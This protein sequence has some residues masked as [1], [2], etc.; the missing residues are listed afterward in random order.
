[1]KRLWALVHKLYWRCV[2][3]LKEGRLLFVL[4]TF[5]HHRSLSTSYV[6]DI[7]TIRRNRLRGADEKLVSEKLL[8]KK[9]RGSFSQVVCNSNKLAVLRWNDNKTVTFI[10]SY[11]DSEP[12]QKI[13]RYCKIKKAKIYVDCPNMVKVYNK[14]MG[15]VDLS[16]MLIS[17]YRIPFKSRRWYLN[18]FSQLVDICIN[19]GWLLYR[20]HYGLKHVQ[21]KPLKIFQHDLVV[22]LT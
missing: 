9:P 20:K 19:N 6:K 3:R 5:F 8:K 12:V 16:D 18:I 14:S 22:A 17:L 2:S 10:S 15:G 4:T 1:M 7:G 21:S 13:K 11:V